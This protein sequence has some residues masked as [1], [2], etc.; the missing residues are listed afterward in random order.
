MTWYAAGTISWVGTA[1]RIDASICFNC[2]NRSTLILP[3]KNIF[4]CD[5]CSKESVAAR[6]HTSVFMQH[7]VTTC[8]RNSFHI[9]VPV[10]AA[11]TLS[12]PIFILPMLFYQLNEDAVEQW[13][14]SA[15]ETEGKS[16]TLE[17]NK[18]L[19]FNDYTES[20]AARCLTSLLCSSKVVRICSCL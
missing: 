16:S 14:D 19:Q 13:C 8:W 1:D 5:H 17:K 4:G 9:E 15:N 20:D 6:V 2:K 18:S 11:P 12:G 10:H 3:L 7:V